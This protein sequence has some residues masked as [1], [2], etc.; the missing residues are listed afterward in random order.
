MKKR[1]LFV[2][3]LSS[4]ALVSCGES[5]LSDSS[6]N[7]ASASFPSESASVFPSDS[8]SASDSSRKEELTKEPEGVL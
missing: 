4:L 8:A 3:L 1:L 7:S 5:N 2:L 6:N